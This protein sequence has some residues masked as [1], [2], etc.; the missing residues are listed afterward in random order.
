MR[1]EKNR[2]RGLENKR[3]KR[4]KEVCPGGTMKAGKY[5]SFMINFIKNSLMER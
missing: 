1:S 3:I 5:T 2:C 4:A